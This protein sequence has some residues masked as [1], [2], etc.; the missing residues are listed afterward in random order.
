MTKYVYASGQHLMIQV[1]VQYLLNLST[2]VFKY[3]S[4]STRH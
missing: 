1:Q 2:Q 3:T 4:T